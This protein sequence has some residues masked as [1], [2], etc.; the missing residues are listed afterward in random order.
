MRW[1]AGLG[2]IFIGKYLQS[3]QLARRQKPASSLSNLKLR[4]LSKK[5]NDGILTRL[6]GTLA[7]EIPIRWNRFKLRRLT[8]S[9]AVLISFP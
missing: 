2:F 5:R 1:K 8:T 4:P 3:P 7:I 6:H 9:T